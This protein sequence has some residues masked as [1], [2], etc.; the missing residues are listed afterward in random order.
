MV[1]KACDQCAGGPRGVEAQSKA[2][3]SAPRAME[4]M[5]DYDVGGFKVTFGP[6]DHNASDFVD[7]TIITRDG[8]FMH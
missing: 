8:K 6:G 4:S 1:R 5:G 7:L 3:A 2:R